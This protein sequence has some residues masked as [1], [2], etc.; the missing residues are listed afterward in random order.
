M[1]NFPTTTPKRMRRRRLLVWLTVANVVGM[2]VLWCMI[3]VVSEQW[4]VGSVVTF[5]PRLPWLVPGVVLLLASVLTWSRT[6]W[7][8]LAT[9]LFT[10]VLIVGFNVPWQAAWEQPAASPVTANDSERTVRVVSANVQDFEPD[11]ATLLREVLKANPDIIAFQEAF[12][13]PKQ[14]ARQFSNWQSVHVR[15]FWVGSKWPLK[16]LGQCDSDVFQ[17]E[18]AIAVEVDAPFGKFVLTDLHLMT[19]RKSLVHLTPRSVL[20]GDGP[21]HVAT[22]LAERDLE[23]RQTRVFMADHEH[24]VP[25]LVCG[26]FNM[27]TSSSIYQA[28]FG[29]YANAFECV[30]WGCGYTAPCRRIRF[31]PENMPWQRIDHILASHQWQAIECHIGS[32]DGSDHRLIAATLRLRTPDKLEPKDDDSR[33]RDLSEEVESLR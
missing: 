4:W 6:I 10:L 12:R 26:D 2:A 3:S 9:V 28:Y 29:P 11:F 24:R 16:L 25:L 7:V 20:N 8:N 13:P 14:L 15:G 18:T 19:A 17:R 5:L 30:A 1:M 23:A 32:R 31:W 22:A 27:P 21:E 33:P